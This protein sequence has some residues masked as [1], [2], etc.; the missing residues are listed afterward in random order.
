MSPWLMVA[1]APQRGAPWASLRKPQRLFLASLSLLAVFLI[2]GACWLPIP[3]S[4]TARSHPEELGEPPT[5]K[6]GWRLCIMARAGQYGFG[7]GSAAGSLRHPGWSALC[8][9]ST[10]TAPWSAPWLRG[11]CEDSEQSLSIMGCVQ[12]FA[13]VFSALSPRL[14]WGQQDGAEPRQKNTVPVCVS[15]HEVPGDGDRTPL[16]FSAQERVLARRPPGAPP[17]ASREGGEAAAGAPPASLGSFLL[18]PTQVGGAQN[19]LLP[20]PGFGTPSRPVSCR[21]CPRWASRIN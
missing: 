11:G 15:A 6:P 19:L 8:L 17:V 4:S 1:S 9:S 3:F 13:I 7:S 20:S 18:L 2:G 16:S 14:L 10:V 21:S 5:S 12:V